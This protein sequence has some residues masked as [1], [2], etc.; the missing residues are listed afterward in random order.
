MKN[1][2]KMRLKAIIVILVTLMLACSKKQTKDNG[3]CGETP[4]IDQTAY[5]NTSTANYTITNAVVN[6]DCLEVT[7]GASG[8]SGSSWTVE[9]VDS[10]AILDSN[11]VQRLIKLSLINNELCTAIFTKT[12]SFD[13]T[14]LQVSGSRSVRLTLSGYNGGLLYHY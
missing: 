2:T 13:I 4:V 10:E 7:F 12:V 9:L 11:P 3:P 14:G 8:C 5:M 6:G 1:S